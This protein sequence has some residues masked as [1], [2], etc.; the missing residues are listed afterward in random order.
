MRSPSRHWKKFS[1]SQLAADVCAGF[2]EEKEFGDHFRNH[3]KKL[4][5]HTVRVALDRTIEITKYWGHQIRTEGVHEIDIFY[6]N[7]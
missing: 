3:G 5:I 4:T 1:K 2:I 6:G 7:S